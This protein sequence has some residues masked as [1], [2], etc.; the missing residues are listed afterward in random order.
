M[1]VTLNEIVQ[2]IISLLSQ[3]GGTGSQRYSQP[4]IELIVNNLF[5]QLYVRQ[6]W[7]QLMDWYNLP[8]DGVNGLPV[9]DMSAVKRYEDIKGVFFDGSDMPLPEL[10][11]TNFN[12]INVAPGQGL[13]ISPQNAVVDKVFRVWSPTTV[14][15]V[16]FWARLHPGRYTSN[17]VVKFDRTALVLGG[18]WAYAEDDGSNPGATQKFQNMFDSRMSILENELKDK[19][20]TTR[21]GYHQIPRT[22]SS[23]YA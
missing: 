13:Y 7:P 4:R 15:N 22:W 21:P 8:L 18:A 16:Q 14:G 3:A 17:Q 11:T 19:P 20:I 6:W 1:Y 12:P 2:D 23:P 5:D 10:P 9:G